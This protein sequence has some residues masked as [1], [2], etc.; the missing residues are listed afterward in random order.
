MEKKMTKRQMFEMIKGVNAD[1]AEIVAFCD[2]EL[3]LLDKKNVSRGETATQKENAV[4]ST[5]ILDI[6]SDIETAKTVTELINETE[7]GKLTFGKDQKAMTNQ[8][9]SRLINDLAKDNKVV[10]VETKGVAYFKIA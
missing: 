1:N 4:L 2:K 7:I 5:Q 3:A 10:R 8:K 9:L 6:L